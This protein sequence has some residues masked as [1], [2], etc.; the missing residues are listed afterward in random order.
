[1]F[2][3]GDAELLDEND[4]VFRRDGENADAVLGRRADD[5]V[6]V[7]DA[8]KAQPA[9]FKKRFEMGHGEKWVQE[10]LASGR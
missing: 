1:V 8:V 6:P 3:D 4:F 7:A 9:G 5:K 10:T 2:L